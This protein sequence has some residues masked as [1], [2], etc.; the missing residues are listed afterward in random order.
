MKQKKAIV[1]GGT[2]GIG[3]GITDVL[4]ANQYKVGITGIEKIVIENLQNS[5]K[6]NLKTEYLD[7]ITDDISVAIN[8]LVERL[9]GL[10]LLIFSAGIGNLNKNLGFKIENNANQLNVLAFTEIA[11]WSYR[12]FEKQ[13]HGHL[14]AI[15]SVSGLFG[16][17][18]APAYHAAKSYQIAYLE[19]LRQKA[20]KSRKS[21]KS[22]YITDVRPG[23]V[24]TP[25]TEGKRLFWAATIETAGTQIYR[26]INKKATIG[27]VSKRWQIIAI[28]IK[29]LPRWIRNRM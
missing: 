9:G 4:L 23:F 1:I 20:S 29:I 5:G 2:S 10:D 21:G 3:K 22:I 16:S 28:V 7:C 12:F 8:Q 25:L 27:Y 26:L 11:D 13:G 6:E 17:R 24:I 14:V 18:V 19:G 15:S